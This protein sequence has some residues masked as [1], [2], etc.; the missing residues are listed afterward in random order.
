MTDIGIQPRGEALRKA[1]R[2]LGELGRTDPLTV[3][4]AAVRFD[5][6]PLEEAFL[7]E[8]FSSPTGHTLP[9]QSGR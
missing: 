1:V 5:L 2:W 9:D 4:E 7:I 3:E 8:Y 6:S